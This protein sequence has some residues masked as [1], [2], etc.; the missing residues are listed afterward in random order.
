MAAAA[1]AEQEEVF[2]DTESEES[3]E[4]E[5]ETAFQREQ[6]LF[7]SGEDERR[8]L[9]EKE[10][11]AQS[12]Q[13][14]E[15]QAAYRV[16]LRR[17]EEEERL[18]AL[19]KR[20]ILVLLWDGFEE[21]TAVSIINGLRAAEVNVVVAAVGN[22][23]M[24]ANCRPSVRVRGCHGIPVVADVAFESTSN[25]NFHLFNGIVVPG[26][27]NLDLMCKNTKLVSLVKTMS[28]KEKFICGA[29]EVPALLFDRAK[30]IKG[31]CVTGLPEQAERLRVC[32]KQYMGDE[33]VVVDYNIIT[34]RGPADAIEFMLTI[35]KCIFADEGYAC[36]VA[37]RLGYEAY[38][39]RVEERK[40][41]EAAEAAAEAEAKEAEIQAEDAADG[42][43]E[44]S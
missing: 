2:T 40:R 23:G 10:V 34:A 13:D 6:Y 24:G 44:D 36:K 12:S 16:E 28:Y 27:D 37:E 26:G 5:E 22:G 42:G 18:V 20:N 41:Q 29:S 39:Q 4:A 35:V 30:I 11:Q 14:R 17:R 33:A 25:A 32:S 8:M 1:G 3:Y 38:T 9:K 19:G 15:R 7:V 31:R 21:M 43:G